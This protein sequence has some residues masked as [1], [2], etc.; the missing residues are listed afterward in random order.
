MGGR[1]IL[2]GRENRKDEAGLPSLF[3]VPMVTKFS[4]LW[5]M[6]KIDVEWA[7]AD[8]CLRYCGRADVAI[9]NFSLDEVRV[10]QRLR[11]FNQSMI[12]PLDIFTVNIVA[13]Y[14]LNAEVALVNGSD[15]ARW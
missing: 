13:L 9:S 8:V 3:F 11:P 15:L 12:K 6:N 10:Q 5:K 1:G 4:A 7:E 2:I 14:V